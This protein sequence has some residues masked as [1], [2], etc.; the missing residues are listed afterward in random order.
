MGKDR[1]N[2][3]TGGIPPVSDHVSDAKPGGTSNQAVKGVKPV[4]DVSGQTDSMSGQ[5]E[6]G[7]TGTSGSYGGPINAVRNGLSAAGAGVVNLVKD[8]VRSFKESGFGTKKLLSASSSGLDRVSGFLHIPK[9]AAGVLVGSLVLGSVGTGVSVYQQ[10]AFTNFMVQQEDSDDEDDCLE[11]VAATKSSSSSGAMDTGGMA[12]EYAMKAWGVGKAIGM[13]DAQCAAMLGNMNEESHLDPTTIETIYGEPFNIKGAEKQAAVSDLCAFTTTA[14]RMKYVKSNYEIRDWTTSTGCHMA[15]GGGTGTRINSAAYEGSDGHF[16]PGIGL[17]GFTGPQGNALVDYA[18]AGNK[19]W[20]DFELQMAFIIDDT[21]GYSRA[22]LVRQWIIDGED[23]VAAATSWWNINFEGNASNFRIAER[24]AYAQQW[25]NK[26][27][28]TTGDTEFAQSVIGLADSIAGGSAAGSKAA[29]ETDK[30]ASAKKSFDNNDLARA[31]VAYAYETVDEG[32]GNNGTQ[33]YTFVHDAVA[34]GDD[35]YMSCDRGVATA[36]RWTDYDDDFPMGATDQQDAFCQMNSTQWEMVGE[37]G[38]D[39]MYEDLQPGDILITT[40]A[41][42]GRTH[43]H[44]VIYV[45]NEVVQEKY[46]GSDASFV[47]ASYKERSP[48][49]ETWVSGKFYGQGYYVYRCTQPDNSGLYKD[50]AEGKNLNDR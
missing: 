46:P 31:A 16:F 49:C 29:S 33:L 36:V 42:R 48:G 19:D 12:E 7:L 38:N 4:H 17:F 15:G 22:N 39:I 35:W 28:G 43:G 6:S 32:R 20:W 44:I 26:L 45:S 13:S 30:C 11:D 27:K 23:D 18:A 10:H 14:M 41:R 5:A 8:G 34:P 50:I 40:A 47:S 25:Y 2:K 37:F 3:D 9:A 21:G 24:T 1:K